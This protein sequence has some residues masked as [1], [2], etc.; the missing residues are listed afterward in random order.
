MVE[1]AAVLSIIH[2][3]PHPP[4]PPRQQAAAL[5]LLVVGVVLPFIHFALFLYNRLLF[6]KN[7]GFFG[8]AP[9]RPAPYGAAAAS[10]PLGDDRRPLLPN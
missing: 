1:S 7:V 10:S 8:R 3:H 5:V 9:F 6:R 2:A 4:T